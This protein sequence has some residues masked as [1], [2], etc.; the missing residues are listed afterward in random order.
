L[1]AVGAHVAEGHRRGLHHRVGSQSTIK[2]FL[3]FL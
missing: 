1:H 2:S 3:P